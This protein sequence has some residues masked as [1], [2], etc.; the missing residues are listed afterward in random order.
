MRLTIKIGGAG[1][2]CPGRGEWEGAAPRRTTPCP[3]HTGR[4]GG[5]L[6]ALLSKLRQVKDKRMTKE[7]GIVLEAL[8]KAFSDCDVLTTDPSTTPKTS[9]DLN[10]TPNPAPSEQQVT[11]PPTPPKSQT[12]LKNP[13]SPASTPPAQHGTASILNN[14]PHD[15]SEKEK[16]ANLPKSD[17]AGY[18]EENDA[19][20]KI[21][22]DGV[23]DDT[24]GAKREHE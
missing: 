11:D 22:L 14:P 12:D 16:T 3:A 9:T 18:V 6:C 8:F 24:M 20:M 10:K 7:L 13:T 2:E 1:W 23:G 21:G 5:D 4:G 17:V 19:D 15:H